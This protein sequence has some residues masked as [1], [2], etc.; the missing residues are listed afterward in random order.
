MTD[1]A[2]EYVTGPDVEAAWHLARAAEI[3]AFTAQTIDDNGGIV[4][5]DTFNMLF[6]QAEIHAA[7]GNGYATLTVA[8]MPPPP[9]T[10]PTPPPDVYPNG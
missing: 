1:P 10:P 7:I 2:A 4:P 3:M 6:R 5:G 9:A 8:A